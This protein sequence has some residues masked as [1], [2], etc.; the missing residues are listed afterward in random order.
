MLVNEG[1]ESVT[2][3]ELA[4]RANV[5][6][7]APRRH[8]ADREALL[9]AIAAQGFDELARALQAAAGLPDARQRLTSYAR[10][11]IGFARS[12]GPLLSFMFSFKAGG[13]GP[14]AEAAG[15]FFALGSALLGEPGKEPAGPLPYVVAATLEGIAALVTA[16]R[17]PE[18]RTDEV[19]DLAVAMILPYLNL[20]SDTGGFS[21]MP[22]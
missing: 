19:I 6:H 7:A 8:F 16:G 3:R 1:A 12:N 22:S 9:A 13:D 20:D 15:H 17:L 5:S 11:F 14:V 10:H 21:A 18:A 4:R 2:L